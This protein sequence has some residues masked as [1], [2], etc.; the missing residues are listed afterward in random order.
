MID[1]RSWA[2]KTQARM[3]IFTWIEA[4]PNPNRRHSGVAQQSPN[5]FE[6]SI[7]MQ[8]KTQTIKPAQHVLNK[9]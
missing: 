6:R 4:W 9:T 5:S 1:R 7:K 3:D 2:T 8:S